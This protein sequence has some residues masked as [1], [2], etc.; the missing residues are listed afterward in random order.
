[1]D[2]PSK[3][4]FGRRLYTLILNK[5]WRPADLARQ[6]SITRDAVSTYVGGRCLPTPESLDKMARALGVDPEEL[7]PNHVERSVGQDIPSIEFRVSTAQPSQAWL[8]INRLVS[9]KVGAKIIALLE[10][11]D[12]P[13]E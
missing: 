2:D 4:E 1:M 9:T 7:M 13:V 12:P 5:G 3:D 11:D 6:A 8:R 10:E